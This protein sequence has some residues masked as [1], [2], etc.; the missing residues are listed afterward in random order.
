MNF[1]EFLNPNSIDAQYVYNLEEVLT[2][3]LAKEY[4]TACA[5]VNV[6]KVELDYLNSGCSDPSGKPLI[7]I[8]IRYGVANT[9][10]DWQK[11][12]DLYY[13]KSSLDFIAGQFYQVLVSEDQ[14]SKR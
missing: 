6:D 8:H 2:E 3:I 5:Y 1:E 11:E 13:D 7:T 10:E 12:I 4:E 14:E 9:G